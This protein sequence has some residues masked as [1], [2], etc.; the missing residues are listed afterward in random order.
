[1]LWYK[2]KQS[3]LSKVLTFDRQQYHASMIH[4]FT[5]D[6]CIREEVSDRLEFQLLEEVLFCNCRSTDI[7]LRS[8]LQPGLHTLGFQDFELH[9]NI[10][11]LVEMCCPKLQ[12]L[13]ISDCNTPKLDDSRFSKV[14]QSLKSLRRLHLESLP[15][16]QEILGPRIDFLENLEELTLANLDAFDFRSAFDNSLRKCTKLRKVHLEDTSLVNANMLIILSNYVSLEELYINEW[17][18]EEAFEQYEERC[19]R[20]S[21]GSPCFPKLRKLSIIPSSGLVAS[22]LSSVTGN[23]VDLRLAVVHTD[24]Q[25]VCPALSHLP[26]IVHLELEFSDDTVFSAANLDLL[27]KLSKLESLRLGC[28]DAAAG[29]CDWLTDQQFEQLIAKLPQLRHLVFPPVGKVLTFAAVESLARSCPLLEKCE[30]LWEHDLSTWHASEAPLFP[31]LDTLHLGQAKD[32]DDREIWGFRHAEA[33]NYARLLRTLAPR[34]K[35]LCVRFNRRLSGAKSGPIK[36]ALNVDI[37]EEIDPDLW[38]ARMRRMR[39]RYYGR[40]R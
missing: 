24:Q 17:L 14:L 22:L 37:D 16:I 11:D 21:P 33:G 13:T 6:R 1:M 35:D 25:I 26:G 30:L 9:A 8:L 2:S 4:N 28:M 32:H 5:L 40:A 29:C 15:D 34:L 12:S 38:E 3:M 20:R 23:L 31:K 36:K 27:S 39:E 7:Q 10:L 19:S 18:E